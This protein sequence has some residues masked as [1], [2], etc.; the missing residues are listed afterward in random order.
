[1]VILEILNAL[2]LPPLAPPYQGGGCLS[3]ERAVVENSRLGYFLPY[4]GENSF[5]VPLL[6]KEGLGAVELT[7]SEIYSKN[8]R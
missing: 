5:L 3:T 8:N 2:S 4:Q 6:D 1:M 7:H